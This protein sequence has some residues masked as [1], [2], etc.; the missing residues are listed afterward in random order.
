MFQKI[1]ENQNT[2]NKEFEKLN[3]NFLDISQKKLKIE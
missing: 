1:S 2:S 3:E